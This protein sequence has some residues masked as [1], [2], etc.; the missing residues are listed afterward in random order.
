M[1]IYISMLRGINI[2]PHK[3]IKMDDLRKSFEALGF[4]QIKTYIQSGN[5][6]FKTRRTS[7]TLLSKRIEEK[8]VGD[9]GFSV[10]VISRSSDEMAKAVESN[11]FL[12]RRGSANDPNKQIDP[13]KLH[14]MFLSEVP[15]PAALKKLSD[16]VE[17]PD[18]CLSIDR[19]I[20]FYLPNGVSRSILTKKPVDRLLAV[21]T[22]MRN[23]KTVNSLHQ[24]CE[25]KDNDKDCR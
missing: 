13:E 5:V 16:L 24:M 14:L 12:N 9:F 17:A 7:T 8:I 21:V 6:V 25:D 20:Y 18:R 1:P 4:E 22:T 11:P 10:S 19:E 15:A 2:G 23:W 3:R